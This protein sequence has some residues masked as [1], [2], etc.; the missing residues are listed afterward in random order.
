MGAADRF[1]RRIL[2]GLAY[3]GLAL[4]AALLVAAGSEIWGQIFAELM[5]T[6]EKAQGKKRG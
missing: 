6:R 5:E 1:D 2:L 3:A 4:G